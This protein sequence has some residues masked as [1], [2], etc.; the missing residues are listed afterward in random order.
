MAFKFDWNL[1][2]WCMAKKPI[3]KF[4]DLFAGIGGFHVAFNNTKR[5]QCVFASE[6][7]PAARK[8]YRHNFNHGA[9]KAL[10]AN[11]DKYFQG[12]ITK[13]DPKSGIPAFDILC[14]GFPCQPFSQA[15]HKKGFSDTRGTLFFNVEEIIRVK[16]PAAFFLENVRGLITHGGPSET[17][18]GIGKT[19]ETI[20]NHLFGDKKSGGLGYHKPKGTPGY[21]YV[22]ASDFGVPQHRPRV[23]IIGFREKKDA[24]DFN[25]PGRQKLDEN[26]LGMILGGDVFFDEACTKAKAIGFT[27]RCGGKGSPIDDRRNWEHYFVKKRGASRPEVVKINEKHGLL[28]NGFPTDFEFPPNVP[29]KIARM[30]QLGNSVAVTAVQAW[31]EAIIKALDS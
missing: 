25:V 28:L 30:K 3:Y 7:D 24:E 19:M 31:G 15:G 16:Q 27:L 4:I 2:G 12:D 1:L 10:F 14:G 26:R 20:L 17:V 21:F 22:K 6:W 5:A 9:D 13:V 23:F 18:P 8:T 29:S 11:D